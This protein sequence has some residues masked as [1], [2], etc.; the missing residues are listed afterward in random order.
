[1][2]IR[3]DAVFI[4]AVLF[5]IALLAFLPENLIWA[6]EWR[7]QSIIVTD[8][9]ST[10]NLYTPLAFASLA[11]S[12]VGLI[13]IWSGY[14]QRA[15]WAWFVMFVIVWVYAFPVYIRPVLLKLPINLSAWFWEAVKEGGPAR[16]YAKG[17]LVFLLMVVALF[18]PLKAFFQKRRIAQTVSG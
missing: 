6:S 13:V 1:M 8:W 16:A 7:R 10:G 17:T 3:R 2:K 9:F 4:S 12:L 18:M 5:T 11:I 14:V 15:R